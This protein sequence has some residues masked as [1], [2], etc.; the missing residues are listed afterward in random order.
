MDNENKAIITSVRVAYK[1]GFS[2]SLSAETLSAYLEMAKWNF[3]DKKRYRLHKAF[4]GGYSEG[5]KLLRTMPVEVFVSQQSS[6]YVAP[7]AMAPFK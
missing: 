4:I 2:V 3:N 5:R 7:M 6:T 1:I